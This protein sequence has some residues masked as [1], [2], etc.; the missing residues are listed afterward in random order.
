[1]RGRRWKALLFSAV[2][3]VVPVL[4]PAAAAEEISS[5]EENDPKEESTY[6]EDS[7]IEDSIPEPP[8]ENSVQESISQE[9]SSVQSSREEESAD[10]SSQESAAPENPDQSQEDSSLNE[11]SSEEDPPDS[12][13]EESSPEDSSSSEESPPEDSF[14]SDSSAEESSE[15]PD[16]TPPEESS[17]PE[18]SDADSQPPEEEPT[19]QPG[20][21]PDEWAYALTP[22]EQIS[23]QACAGVNTPRLHAPLRSNP[24]YYSNRNIYYAAGYGMPNCTA[25]A[26]GRSYERLEDRPRLSSHNAG[27]WWFENI[28]NGWYAYGGRPRVGAVACWDR[29]DQNQGHVAVVEKVDGDRVTISESGYQSFLF[30]TTE[31]AADGS[32][33]LGGG[34][35]FLGYIYVETGQAR[36]SEGAMSVQ[37]GA[38]GMTPV[39]EYLETDPQPWQVRSEEGVN[40]R[41]GYGLDEEV[42]ALIPDGTRLAV[43]QTVIQDGYTWGKVVYQRQAGWCVL[44]F[45][46]GSPELGLKQS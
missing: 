32:D 23:D 4:Q 43:L 28:A 39:V 22:W 30:R 24:Y 46:Q 42:L 8:V 44:D 13:L 11:S 26:Y 33:Y 27:E 35:R 19:A 2:W 34:Y 10:S 31:M 38:A 17:L 45:G 14:V 3:A 25:Y 41:G 36:S 40:L 29:Y 18:D 21:Y 12:S 1:M 16:S 15:P 20:P 9:E 5:Y 6:I 7:I 37:G